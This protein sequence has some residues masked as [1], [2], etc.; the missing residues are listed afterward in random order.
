MRS[1]HEHGECHRRSKVVVGGQRG[2][3]TRGRMSMRI[4]I[5]I[6]YAHAAR[7]KHLDVPA[8]E[9]V[10]ETRRL[11]RAAAEAPAAGR[12]Q[13][14]VRVADRALAARAEYRHEIARGM[15][16]GRVGEWLLLDSHGE[17]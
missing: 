12:A 10:D 5:N 4:C 17:G 11:G 2:E 13:Q 3:G 8:H 14:L 9:G 6:L 1:R 15:A 7:A 16:G